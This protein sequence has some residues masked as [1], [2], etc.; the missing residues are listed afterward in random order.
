M[1]PKPSPGDHALALF[2]F[3]RFAYFRRVAEAAVREAGIHPGLRFRILEHRPEEM[4]AHKDQPDIHGVI[5]PFLEPKHMDWFLSRNTRVILFSSRMPPEQIPAGVGWIRADDLAIGE[6]AAHHFERM[7]LSHTAFFGVEGLQ[8]SE[9][10]AQ[11]FREALNNMDSPRG[12]SC[13]CKKGNTALKDFLTTLPRPCGIFCSDDSHARSLLT[14]AIQLGFS[15]PEDFAVIGVDHDLILSELSPLRLSSVIPDAETLGQR[16]VQ[17]LARC[18][19]EDDMPGGLRELVSPKG[20][21]Y[22][23]S[24]PYYHSVDPTVA[25]ALQWMEHHLADPVSIDDLA[26]A[27]AASRRNL[28]YLFK[29][30]LDQGP[31]QQLLHMR[32]HLAKRLL[33]HSQKNMTDIAE[34]CG[35]TNAREFSVRFKDKTGQT[36]SQYREGS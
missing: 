8:Y 14:A 4:F 1:T 27:C 30:H 6:A 2:G 12:H 32:L 33:R 36:P 20:I 16:A 34:A 11:G 31:Y 13:E 18:F 9:L 3:E 23:E 21:H 5:A 29:K 7:G 35:F 22:D 24:A 26:R 19:R 17:E 25:R 10:R 15:V 28:E